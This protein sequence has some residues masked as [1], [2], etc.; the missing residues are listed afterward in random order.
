[1]SC[2]A[3]S[4]EPID[5]HVEGLDEKLEKNVR[6]HL[7]LAARS[8]EQAEEEDEEPLSDRAVRRLHR[9]ALGEIRQALQPFGYYSPTVDADL[10]HSDDGWTATYRIEPGPATRIGHR[11][12]RVEGEARKLPEVEALLADVPVREGDVL[13]HPAYNTL[14]RGLL[15]AAYSTGFLDT[16]YE[17]SEILVHPEQRRAEIYLILNS[18]PR[19]YFGD[20]EIEQDI[21]K[22]D[23]VRQYNDIER[24]EPFDTDRLIALQLALSGSDYFSNVDV[25]VDREN[26]TD[27]HIPVTIRTEPRNRQSYS[28]GAGY[29][30]DTGARISLRTEHRR[31]NRRGHQFNAEVRLSEVRNSFI[32]QYHV[33]IANIATDR[34][35]YFSSLQQIEIGD[36]DSDQF[37]IGAS[38]EDNWRNLRRSLYLRFDR[39]NFRFGDR[40]GGSA[41][42]LYPGINLAYQRADDP[43]FPRHGFSAAL[44]VHGGFENA[45]SETTFVQSTFNVRAVY[46]LGDRGRLLL[47]GEAGATE[48]DSFMK[49]PPSQRFFTGGDRTVRGYGFEELSPEDNFGNDIGGQYLMV[50]SVEADYLVKGNFGAAVFY[51]TGNATSTRSRDLVSGVGIGF[52][53]RS[54]VGMIR[55]DLAHPLDDPD[56][57]FRFHVSLGPDL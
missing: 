45:L 14:K 44:D 38:R 53:Y 1:M 20:I 30:T 25:E 3:H 34:M 9:Q 21:L 17:R 13:S 15:E 52:R 2:A 32:T 28:V 42:L 40:P 26:V 18:G 36:A 12:I 39:E 46:P 50:G 7:S 8:R 19:Y 49:L 54:P 55:L 24:G 6:A 27:H 31:I 11:E 57:S 23:F 41:S 47:R 22:P 10:T 43:L 51:D 48:V 5:I 35:T 33:P 29:G 37:S 4:A 56:R 16:A